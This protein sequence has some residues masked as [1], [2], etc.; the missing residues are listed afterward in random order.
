MPPQNH[1]GLSES[2]Q[3]SRKKPKLSNNVRKHLSSIASSAIELTSNI[4][5]VG[6][7]GCGKTKIINRIYN[8]LNEQSNT[9]I[10]IK[11]LTGQDVERLRLKLNINN[12]K[13]IEMSSGI[14]KDQQVVS[15]DDIINTNVLIIDDFS[16]MNVELF[17][18]IDELLQEKHENSKAFGGINLIMAG[19]PYLLA[20]VKGPPC[21]KSNVWKKCEFVIHEINN[22]LRYHGFSWWFHILKRVRCGQAN[23]EDILAINKLHKTHQDLDNQLKGNHE[24]SQHLFGHKNNVKTYNL[25]QLD[26]IKSDKHILEA[27]DQSGIKVMARRYQFPVQLNYTMTIH[28]A[29]GLEF[30]SPVIHSDDFWL[31]AQFYSALSRGSVPDNIIIASNNDKIEPHF[32]NK[33]STHGDFFYR[34]IMK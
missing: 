16:M 3:V 17:E 22:S 30:I 10:V 21:F 7:A 14:G 20:P 27:I 25:K 5:L 9:S 34:Q 4:C 8:T 29:Q 31:P 6:P 19:D 2:S 13:T 11:K 33:Y 24:N 26:C 23:D 15:I 32:V 18:W 12:A 1:H 28:S